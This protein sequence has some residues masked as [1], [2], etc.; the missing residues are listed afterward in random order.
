MSFNSWN[1]IVFIWFYFQVG[2]NFKY[3]LLLIYPMSEYPFHHVV[4]YTLGFHGWWKTC[5][6]R[7][8]KGRQ[9]YFD[10]SSFC[11]V[12][13]NKNINQESLRST[14]IISQY[15]GHLNTK[16]RGKSWS[17]DNTGSLLNT[18]NFIEKSL[19]LSHFTSFTSISIM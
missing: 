3:V 13:D 10:N 9:C 19:Q 8:I 5:I 2:K 11:Q 7:G 16:Q 17:Q 6:S 1:K 4:I 12:K 18:F 14:N 15:K